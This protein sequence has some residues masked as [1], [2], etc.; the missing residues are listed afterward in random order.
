MI[1]VKQVRPSIMI[2]G[3]DYYPQLENS[4]LS[5]SYSDNLD[6]ADDLQL[7]LEDTGLAWVRNGMPNKGEVT[8][9]AGIYV[10]PDRY[11]LDCGSF[12]V[13]QVSFK[14]P[15]NTMSIAGNSIPVTSTLKTENQTRAWEAKT[16]REIAEDIA[17]ENGMSVF[18]D[19]AKNPTFKRIDQTDQTPMDFLEAQAKEAGLILKVKRSEIKIFSEAEYELKEP[20]F[21][22]R[23][24]DRGILGWSFA[25]NTEGTAKE[26]NV[27]YMDPETGKV[28]RAKAVDPSAK[29]NTRKIKSYDNPKQAPDLLPDPREAAARAAAWRAEVPPLI[30][31]DQNDNTVA[32]NKGKGANLQ[33]KATDKA[34]ADL[35][36]ANRHRDTAQFSVVGNPFA[37]AG[38]TVLLVDWGHWDG[39]YF[40]EQVSH[41]IGPYNCSYSLHREL[42]SKGY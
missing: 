3:K 9:E 2:A 34:K 7:E 14:G 40:L 29:K 26:A 15:P 27:D 10:I 4:L 5:F 16:L 33:A 19:A 24:G 32:K 17:K 12:Q 21:V 38:Q 39:K 20:S 6:K 22:L 13:D 1:P 28:T 42:A 36:K 37:A 8:I 11:H 25:T 23:Y 31:Y 30:D 35:R 41:K 18:W